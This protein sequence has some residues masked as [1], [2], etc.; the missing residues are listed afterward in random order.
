MNAT[1][2]AKKIEATCCCAHQNALRTSC[3]RRGH[4]RLQGMGRVIRGAYCLQHA[5]MMLQRP[6]T[7]DERA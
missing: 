7:A 3:Q 4:Y 1:P 2:T 5:E 6:L